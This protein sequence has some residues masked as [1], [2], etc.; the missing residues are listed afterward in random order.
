MDVIKDRYD[1]QLH[2]ATGYP[3]K[4]QLMFAAGDEEGRRAVRVDAFLADWQTLL[5]CEDRA[6]SDGFMKDLLGEIFWAH[7]PLIRLL[8]GMNEM[9]LENGSAGDS[10]FERQARAATTRWP[11]SK[12][13]EDVLLAIV[14]C[15]LFFTRDQLGLQQRQ[16]MAQKIS[17]MD[18][19]TV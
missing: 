9:E 6:L 13:V 16:H 14:V 12:G 7:W 3:A 2:L 11:D 18:G 19:R 15:I 5:T 8:H 1:T 4:F 17:R 10:N